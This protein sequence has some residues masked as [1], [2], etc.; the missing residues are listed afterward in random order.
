MFGTR[1]V[2]GNY[3]AVLWKHSRLS[4]GGE[5]RVWEEDKGTK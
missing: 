1:E 5:G 4:T 2:V 3:T